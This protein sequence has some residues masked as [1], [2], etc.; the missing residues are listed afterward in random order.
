MA[1]I[2]LI[3]RKTWNNQSINQSS[4]LFLR[5]PASVCSKDG[6]RGL[7]CVHHWQV[8]LDLRWS[9]PWDHRT[10]SADVRESSVWEKQGRRRWRRGRRKEEEE[11]EKAQ[12]PRQIQGGPGIQAEVHTDPRVTVVFY[13][14]GK[15]KLSLFSCL[16]GW[17]DG[18]ISWRMRSLVLPLSLFSVCLSVCLSLSLSLSLSFSLVFFCG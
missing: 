10:Y 4:I 6:E 15:C 7:R 9:W 8:P 5:A 11:E 12:V 17:R 18:V 14:F 2:L 3:R 16:H 13:D 1:E